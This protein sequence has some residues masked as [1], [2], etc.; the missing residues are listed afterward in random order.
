[1]EMEVSL[2]TCAVLTEEQLVRGR[3]CSVFTRRSV[4]GLGYP[5]KWK[6]WIEMSVLVRTSRSQMEI[7]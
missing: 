6:A 2:I 4:L 5:S 7:K 1:M 3:W